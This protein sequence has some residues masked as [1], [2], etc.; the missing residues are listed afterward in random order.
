[1]VGAQ[2]VA[3]DEQ[4]IFDLAQATP[5]QAAHRLRPASLRIILY[6]LRPL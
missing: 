1:V 4:D 5:P 3:H 2:L 6:L